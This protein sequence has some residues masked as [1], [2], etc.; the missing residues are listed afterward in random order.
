MNIHKALPGLYF[1]SGLAIAFNID[2]ALGY[3]SG[4]LLML[5]AC[6]IW[7]K[8]AESRQHHLSGETKNIHSQHHS[9]IDAI[10]N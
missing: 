5:I 1:C 10:R 8:R 2:S 6:I 3:F 7:F 9:R 4:N